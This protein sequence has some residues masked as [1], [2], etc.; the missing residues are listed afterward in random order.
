MTRLSCVLLVVATLAAAQQTAPSR[1]IHVH[2]PANVSAKSVDIV[3]FLE[4]PFGGHSA[5]VQPREDQRVYPIPMST[6]ELATTRMKAVVWAK[7]C[8]LQ[9]YDLDLLH[10]AERELRYECIAPSTVLLTG[11][12][13]LND[14]LRKKPHQIAISYAASWVCGF[15]GLG[16]CM[17]PGFRVGTVIPAEDETFTIELPDFSRVPQGF[18][19]GMVVSDSSFSLYML[20]SKMTPLRQ[21]RPEL[22]DVTAPDGN[23]KV[24]SAYP[25][26]LAFSP[27]YAFN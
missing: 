10:S 9:T 22:E 6:T 14:S 21:L 4:G 24:L 20:D 8:E 3:Y 19:Q 16:D 12:L 13:L 17:V 27:H 23:L 15:F 18:A 11:R 7:G 25:P 5:Q 26:D 1:C 2:L